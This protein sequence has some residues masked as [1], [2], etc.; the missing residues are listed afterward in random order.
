MKNC[1]EIESLRYRRMVWIDELISKAKSSKT[2][3]TFKEENLHKFLINGETLNHPRNKVD[4]VQRI[5]MSKR[6]V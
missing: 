4:R 6:M 1:G 3:E 5:L 2:L